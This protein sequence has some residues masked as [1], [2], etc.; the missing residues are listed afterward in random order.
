M[1]KKHKKLGADTTAV[2]HQDTSPRI[3][4]RDKIKQNLSIRELNWTERQK[5]LIEM[6]LD[7]NVKVVFI[8][9]PAGTSKT[10]V[11]AY[12]SLQLL[13]A[14]RVSDIL[15]YVVGHMTAVN[16]NSFSVFEQ[17]QIQFVS[18]VDMKNVG[19]LNSSQ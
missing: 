18:V 9:G 6:A 16:K 2:T 17:R 19:A 1:G 8:T 10:L 13:N 15:V 5:E 7:K 11:A 4:Q 14:K 12:C 3:H